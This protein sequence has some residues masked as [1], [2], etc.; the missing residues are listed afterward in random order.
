MNRVE[1]VYHFTFPWLITYSCGNCFKDLGDN[2]DLTENSEII[3][4]ECNCI[5]MN[6]FAKS[7]NVIGPKDLS[8]LVNEV[9]NE[10]MELLKDK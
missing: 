4:P 5:N 6:K 10:V 8:K 7:T 2:L 1:I 3:C 9:N